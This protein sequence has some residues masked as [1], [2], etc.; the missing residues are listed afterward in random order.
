MSRYLAYDANGKLVYL[1]TISES[2]GAADAD[3]P[4]STDPVTGLLDESVLPVGVGREM[5][6]VAAT[7]AIGA[8]KFVQRYSLTGVKKVR[9]AD[10]TGKPADGFC[11]ESVAS[12]ADA[13][14]YDLGQR[15]NALS[16]LTIGEAYF[17]GSAGGVVL[18]S[19]LSWAVDDIIQELG[20][21]TDTGVIS[22]RAYK[23]ATVK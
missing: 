11:M 16:G 22:T 3:K 2:A 6:V 1:E 13:K 20:N 15:N 4:V 21:A 7:E 5:E 23:P 12:G 14:V 8:G 9:L 18:G 17:L 10:K 19:G